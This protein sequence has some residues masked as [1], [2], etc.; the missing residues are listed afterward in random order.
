[1]DLLSAALEQLSIDL[2]DHHRTGAED[3][4]SACLGPQPS[5]HGLVAIDEGKP[6]G[7]ALISPIFSTTRGTAGVYISDLWVAASMRGKGLGRRL[8]REVAA[9]GAGHWQARFLKLTVYADNG[10]ARAFYEYLGFRIAENDQTFLL[11]DREME[12]LMREMA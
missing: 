7:A 1:M 9:F 8:L 11:A 6:V 2:G 4:A 12:A 3:L 5:C 10:P